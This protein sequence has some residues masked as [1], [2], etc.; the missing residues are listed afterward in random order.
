M[1]VDGAVVAADAT[2]TGDL[3]DVGDDKADDGKNGEPMQ[4]QQGEHPTQPSPR[5]GGDNPGVT[6]PSE[7]SDPPAVDAAAAA[8]AAAA[9][10]QA[11]AKAAPSW[12]RGGGS[13]NRGGGGGR[14]QG[15]DPILPVEDPAVLEVS[16]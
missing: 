2:T 12:V 10:T 14:F 13:R 9:D 8:A 4:E 3:I 1:D 6:P 7:G 5:V 16:E 15:V 11:Q